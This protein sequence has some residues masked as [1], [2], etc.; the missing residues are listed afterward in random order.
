MSTKLDGNKW[1]VENYDGNKEVKVAVEKGQSVYIY[2]IKDSVVQ[3]TGK[4]STLSGDK[5]VKSGVIYESTVGS[6]EI[7]NSSRLQ[8]QGSSPTYAVDKSDGVTLFLKPEDRAAT[9]ITSQATEVN[10]VVMEE[11]KDPHEHPVPSQFVTEYKN[12][13]WATN[14]TDHVG[15]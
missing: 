3:I 10:I 8:L 11:G 6:A 15:V 9:I 7:V 12:G 4:L 2:N 5:C 13:V 14:P 1:M